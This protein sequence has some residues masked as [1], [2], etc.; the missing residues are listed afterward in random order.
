ME[1]L[2]LTAEHLNLL[3]SRRIFHRHRGGD[4]LKVGETIG[5]DRSCLIEPYSHIFA[6]PYLPL[7][8]GA[9]SYSN[10]PLYVHVA[11]G[12]YCSIAKGVTWMG[13]DHGTQTTTTYPLTS[14]VIL[15]GLGVYYADRGMPPPEEEEVGTGIIRIGHDVW[16]GEQAMIAPGVKIGHG[17]VVGA[18]SLVLK[19]VPPYAVVVG[20]PAK[21]L[22]YRF[23]ADLIA[24]LLASEWWR[25]GPECL[26]VGAGPEKT[27]AAL[28]GAKEL[29]LHPLSGSELIPSPETQ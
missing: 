10:A 25:Y 12:R 26:P 21:V 27:L 23:D 22:R 16:I 13:N 28:V 6:G 8:M 18:R 11:I 9:F 5:F 4:R 17:A 19:D 3:R 1:Y 20:H 29:V 14:P 7:R 15:A 24:A 2:R